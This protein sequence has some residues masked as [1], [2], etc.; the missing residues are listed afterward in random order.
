MFALLCVK[1]VCLIVFPLFVS[2]CFPFVCIS[3]C[4]TLF[5][6]D[7]KNRF[8]MNP[9]IILQNVK[10]KVCWTLF[11]CIIA[12]V[13]RSELIEFTWMVTLNDWMKKSFKL[14][15]ICFINFVNCTV[16]QLRF[17]FN[18]TRMYLAWLNAWKIHQKSYVAAV[19][20]R[21]WAKLA[22]HFQF[23]ILQSEIVSFLYTN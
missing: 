14:W 18:L 16:G 10:L 3:I 23:V 12:F 2:V 5:Q 22:A 1:W 8:H 20:A 19:K 21:I 6:Y 13:V 15:M 9:C 7:F 17:N 11:V 4:W